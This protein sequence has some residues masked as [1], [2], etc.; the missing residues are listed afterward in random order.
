MSMQHSAQYH[1]QPIDGT[2]LPVEIVFIGDDPEL[3]DMYGLKLRLDG[4]AVTL[5]T[6][7]EA[8]SDFLEMPAPDIVYLDIGL[9]N[10]EGLTVHRMLRA[11][12]STKRLPIVLLSTRH[13]WQGSSTELK[14]GLYDFFISS[15]TARPEAFW[16]EGAEARQSPGAV[17]S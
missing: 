16:N 1:R 14:L 8:N 3:A 4:Y 15:D 12:R 6:T 13:T 17:V 7:K 11:Q 9:L 2:D 5:L 10:P